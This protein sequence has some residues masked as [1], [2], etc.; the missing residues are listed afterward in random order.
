MNAPNVKWRLHYTSPRRRHST[1]PR[2]WLFSFYQLFARIRSL[3]IRQRPHTKHPCLHKSSPISEHNLSLSEEPPTL[4][5]KCVSTKRFIIPAACDNKHLCSLWRE[6]DIVRDSNDQKYIYEV[7]GKHFNMHICSLDHA[8]LIF[9]VFLLY[10]KDFLTPVPYQKL[11]CLRWVWVHDN[12]DEK[13]RQ[14][15]KQKKKL[16]M[17]NMILLILWTCPG[18]TAMSMEI[19]LE[20]RFFLS[21]AFIQITLRLGRLI[22][23]S[24]TDIKLL[25]IRRPFIMV[26]HYQRLWPRKESDMFYGRFRDLFAGMSHTM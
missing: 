24:H 21:Y 12:V 8:T 13:K 18:L 1:H 2:S 20:T 5:V 23:L 14:G 9:M 16:K 3:S 19:M 6:K 10:S 15:K 26:Q 22:P 25:F 11:F 17:W 7:A 4:S